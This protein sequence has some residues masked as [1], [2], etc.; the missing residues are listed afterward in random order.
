MSHR[1]NRTSFNRLLGCLLFAAVLSAAL[2]FGVHYLINQQHLLGRDTQVDVLK[3]EFLLLFAAST[4]LLTLLM[5]FPANRP[6]WFGKN[7]LRLVALL[8]SLTVLWAGGFFY[9]LQNDMIYLHVPQD[10]QAEQA[11]KQDSA[12]VEVTLK[13]KDNEVY[14]G[15]LR[16]SPQPKAGILLYF[17][18]NG[19]LAAR[20]M[21]TFAGLSKTGMLPPYHVLMMDYPSYGQSKGEVGEEGIYRMAQA[22]YD[23]ALS[24]PEVDPAQVVLAGWSLGTGTAVR[25]AAE[26]NPAGLVLIAPYFSGRALVESYAKDNMHLNIPGFL[27]PVR[28][29]YPS[30]DYAKQY[31]S[32]ALVIAARDDDMIAYTQSEKLMQLFAKGQMLTLETGGHNAA[33]TDPNAAIQV[34]AFLKSIGSTDTVSPIL[35]QETPP[36]SPGDIIPTAP[37]A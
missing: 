3:R 22:A 24:L 19:E 23:Y 36:Q 13:G 15:W 9:I 12:Y 7:L 33:W 35:Q 30:N 21:D 26:K 11:L 34:L 8:V 17:G 4:A 16:K 2:L 20:K 27:I 10:V 37:P 14:S 5:V 29:R 1:K 28:N 31:Q 6:N 25:L 18:G 32:P